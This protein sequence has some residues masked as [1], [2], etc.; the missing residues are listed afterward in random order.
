MHPIA[1]AEANR[2]TGSDDKFSSK[3]LVDGESDKPAIQ[4]LVN[5]EHLAEN[6][7]QVS[8]DTLI[9]ALAFAPDGLNIRS[10]GQSRPVPNRASRRDSA[11]R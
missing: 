1:T 5:T 2:L 8:A 7:R 3:I 6:Y 10:Q 11:K 4:M 9:N